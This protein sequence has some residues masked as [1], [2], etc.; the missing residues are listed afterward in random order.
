V[1]NVVISIEL[2]YCSFFHPLFIPPLSSL[3][4]REHQHAV[5]YRETVKDSYMSKL[6]MDTKDAFKNMARNDRKQSSPSP[7][8]T[9]RITNR[10]RQQQ[11]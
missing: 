8:T 3:L 9:S 4:S 5:K 1:Y 10:Q 11:T 7:T 6:K 2:L